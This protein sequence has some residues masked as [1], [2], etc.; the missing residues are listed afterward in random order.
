MPWHCRRGSSVFSLIGVG[1]LAQDVGFPLMVAVLSTL[2][3]WAGPAQVILFGGIAGRDRTTADRHR[4]FAV[5]D[6]ASAHD[7]VHA[8]AAAQP[9]TGGHDAVP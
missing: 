8:A 2:L 6:P 5:L 4:D 9:G 1:S 7:D 3:M